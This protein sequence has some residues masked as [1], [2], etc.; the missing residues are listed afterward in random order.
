MTI[1]EKMIDVNE[2]TS[3]RINPNLGEFVEDVR[4]KVLATKGFD[5]LSKPAI[6]QKELPSWMHFHQAK[7]D[8]ILLDICEFWVYY[9]YDSY[10]YNHTDLTNKIG[11][12]LNQRAN[13]SWDDIHKLILDDIEKQNPDNQTKEME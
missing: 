5:I 11:V 2:Y 8:M 9:H 12:I 3:E 10:I 7:L 4:K 6:A 1:R 13:Y